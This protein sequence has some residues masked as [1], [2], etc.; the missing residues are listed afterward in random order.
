MFLLIGTI[1]GERLLY[2]PSAMTCLAAGYLA[3]AAKRQWLRVALAVILGAWGLALTCLHARYLPQWRDDATIFDYAFRRF[4]QS[5]RLQRYEVMACYNARRLDEAL[6]HVETVRRLMPDYHDF[7]DLR[8]LL[9]G[10]LD[11]PG[12]SE[13]LETAYARY[14]DRMG[15][16]LTRYSIA[17]G[18]WKRAEAVLR[19]QTRKTP[20]MI[21]AWQALAAM[22]ESQG[23]LDDAEAAYAACRDH[24]PDDAVA[25]AAMAD[26][27]ARTGRKLDVALKAAQRALELNPSS[28]AALDALGWTLYRQGK[29][30]D[31]I[32]SL[33][34]AVAIYGQDPAARNALAHLAEAY[35]KA[36]R[37]NDARRASSL[38]SALLDAANAKNANAPK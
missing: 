34:K 17:H 12:A 33:E 1:L 9:M 5:V 6:A 14:P 3:I 27:L 2:L 15:D 26:F 4:P 8:A 18:N 7:D 11:R 24:N 21:N 29:H 19:E 22:L 10:M 38:A 37:Q 30:R 23:R 28:P 20:K 35:S 25:W 36:G 31:A 16:A 13:A 32:A